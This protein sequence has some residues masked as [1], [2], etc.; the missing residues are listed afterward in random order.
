MDPQMIQ[1]RVVK[2][3]PIPGQVSTTRP[4]GLAKHVDYVHITRQNI[5]IFINYTAN[6]HG[7]TFTVSLS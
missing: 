4:I 2:K 6:D 3:I 1:A 5:A 7:T